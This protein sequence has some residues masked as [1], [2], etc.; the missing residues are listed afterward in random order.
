M[1][2][3]FFSKVFSLQIL[4]TQ[5]HIFN[6]YLLIHTFIAYFYT[7]FIIFFVRIL[8]DKVY[9]TMNSTFHLVL[10]SS[11]FETMGESIID[12]RRP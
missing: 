6:L 1:F 2:V 11:Y 10:M 12:T 8:A 3:L 9:K 5:I 7:P 4:I